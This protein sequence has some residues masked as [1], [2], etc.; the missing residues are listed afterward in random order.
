M[1]YPLF[2]IGNKRWGTSQ[3]VRMLNLH[4]L[5]F[6]SDESDISWILYQFYNHR[7]R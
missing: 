4:P 7:G 5:M 2:I 6:V 1:I 3:L